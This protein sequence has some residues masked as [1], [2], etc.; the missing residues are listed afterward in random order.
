MGFNGQGQVA[1]LVT[2]KRN[3][4][5]PMLKQSIEASK[6]RLNTEILNVARKMAHHGPTDLIEIIRQHCKCE[7]DTDYA[8]AIC[9][10][11]GGPS[12]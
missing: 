2:S 12:K 9:K 8:I 6:A 10:E 4:G 5:L 11:F 3:K 1:T 7:L